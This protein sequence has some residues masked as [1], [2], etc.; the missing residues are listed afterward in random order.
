MELKFETK[1]KLGDL[2]NVKENEYVYETCRIC[3]GKKMIRIKNKEF[4]C[5]EC[6]G[7]GVNNYGELK[8]KYEERKI[9]RIDCT[10]TKRNDEI[11]IKYVY[12]SELLRRDGTNAGWHSFYEDEIAGLVEE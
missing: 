6:S 10:F 7:T 8:T 11:K 3:D 5:P 9:D 4:F 1:Y 12:K 2:V